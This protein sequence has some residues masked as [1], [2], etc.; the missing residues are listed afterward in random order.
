MNNDYEGL[1]GDLGKL[2]FIAPGID[3]KPIAKALQGA[4]GDSL[5]ADGLVDFSFRNLTNQF[6]KL[7]Y[8]Y[9]I[10]V[11]ER[12]SLVIRSLLTQELTGR[13]YLPTSLNSAP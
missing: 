2:G 10:R 11:P 9:P 4:W 8:E 12:F 13:L 1:A 7:L 6:N 3:I 5:R